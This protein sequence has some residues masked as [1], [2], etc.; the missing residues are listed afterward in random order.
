[1]LAVFISLQNFTPDYKYE[2]LLNKNKNVPATYKFHV[3][4][5]YVIYS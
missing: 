3:G 1:M 4:A 2:I 5:P